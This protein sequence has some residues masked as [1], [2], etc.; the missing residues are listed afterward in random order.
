MRLTAAVQIPPCLTSVALAHFP[1]L[2][3]Q[4]KVFLEM[5]GNS[6]THLN[7]EL[8]RGVNSSF[9]TCC[10]AF[11]ISFNPLRMT[12]GQSTASMSQLLWGT[13]YSKLKIKIVLFAF[14]CFQGHQHDILNSSLPHP[15]HI[16]SCCVTHDC[17]LDIIFQNKGDAHLGSH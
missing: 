12:W 17:M 4:K 15:K 2:P 14:G 16:L 7:K 11:C 10:Q 1:L 6:A 13:L 5:L 8:R 3:L 9:P